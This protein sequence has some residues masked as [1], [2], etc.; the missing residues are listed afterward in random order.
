M[1]WVAT[2][3]AGIAAGATVY[4]AIAAVQQ[5]RLISL[6]ISHQVEATEHQAHAVEHQAEQIQ[7]QSE[8]I[9]QQRKVFI[10]QGNRERKW[11]TLRACEMSQIHPPILEAAKRIWNKSNGGVDYT[12]LDSDNLQDLI[13]VLNQ[14]EVVA[15]SIEQK[16]FIDYLAYDHLSHIVKKVVPV[17]IRGQSILGC[18]INGAL[19]PEDSY[20]YLTSMHDR[21]FVQ[22]EGPKF[23]DTDQLD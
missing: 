19:V 11:A 7:K 15:I 14:L 9:D 5:L 22:P 12:N 8:A 2:A 23:I 18:K 17:F 6:Q 20:L 16:L 10:E 1:E 4:L 3:A 13:L 21:W